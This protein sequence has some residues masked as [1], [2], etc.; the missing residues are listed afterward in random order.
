MLLKS[1][2][3]WLAVKLGATGLCAMAG[4]PMHA[5][6]RAVIKA[7]YW[8]LFDFTFPPILFGPA[9]EVFPIA[10]YR[11]ALAFFVKD[12]NF[13]N[14][15]Q[16]CDLT[17]FRRAQ[18]TLQPVTTATEVIEGSYSAKEGSR[19]NNFAKAC[20]T[21]GTPCLSVSPW[22]HFFESNQAEISRMTQSFAKERR[23]P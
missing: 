23:C 22:L 3:L 20:N 7:A 4:S 6:N 10:I 16:T 15:L 8:K 21:P 14:I 19:T 11:S 12:D 1:A 17:H 13:C 5:S 18:H 9:C 2:E